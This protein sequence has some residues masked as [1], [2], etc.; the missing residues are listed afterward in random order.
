MTLR[1]R[2]KVV[3]QKQRELRRGLCTGTKVAAILG[4]SKWRTPYDVYAQA[5][6]LVG[7]PEKT[8]AM[9]RGLFL[10][11][12]ILDYF[13]D[14]FQVELER[15]MG[16]LV[17]PT[18][19]WR[20]ASP[21]GLYR[22]DGGIVIVDAKTARERKEWGAAGSDDVPIDYQLQLAWYASV[23]EAYYDVPVV[24]MRVI[25]Y[26]PW[27]DEISTFNL[28]RDPAAEEEVIEKCRQWWW[29]HIIANVA[30]LLDHGRCSSEVVKVPRVDD[31]M[32]ELEYSDQ[33]FLKELVSLKKE[34]KTMEV[35]KKAMENQLKA[36]IGGS[37]GVYGGGH[38]ATWK[39]QSR[40][41][42][43]D[44]TAFQRAHPEMAAEFQKPAREFRVLR[45]K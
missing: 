19:D 20:G 23:I 42:G 22:E 37:T 38:R 13:E 32:E 17:H 4:M 9:A 35:Q 14:V 7:P 43:F 30:P 2:E 24:G 39:E 5:K 40:G 16:T 8:D 21:D 1:K 28:T 12:G 41:G 45:I 10:E 29:R 34:I 18:D 44:A 27:V 3:D 15:G 11:R 31:G 26:F 6:G 25:C 33:L 36:I